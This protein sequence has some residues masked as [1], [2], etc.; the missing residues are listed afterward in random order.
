[1]MTEF[2]CPKCRMINNREIKG[3]FGPHRSKIVCVECDTFIKWTPTLLA[4]S[5]EFPFGKYRGRSFGEIL[6]EDPSYLMWL[7]DQGWIKEKFQ[8]LHDA[9]IAEGL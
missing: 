7:A 5:W 3:E 2:E 6:E 9:I 8:K 4:Y 1:M